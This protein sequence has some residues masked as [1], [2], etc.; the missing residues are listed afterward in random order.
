MRRS[1]RPSRALAR[2]A[3]ATRRMP[4]YHQWRSSRSAMI[5]YCSRSIRPQRLAHVVDALVRQLRVDRQAQDLAGE[6]LGHRQ[7]AGPVAVLRIWRLKMH[8][9]R[10]VD[11]GTDTLLGQVGPDPIATWRSHHEEMEHAIG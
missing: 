11:V 4:A 8:R 9:Q 3:R 1:R 5:A 7:R 10:I 6:P 2:T